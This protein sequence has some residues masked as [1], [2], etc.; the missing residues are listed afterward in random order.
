MEMTALLYPQ[1]LSKSG[2]GE[3]FSSLLAIAVAP[4]HALLGVLICTCA[5]GLFIAV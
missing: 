5:T 3:R 1:G 4:V 2:S